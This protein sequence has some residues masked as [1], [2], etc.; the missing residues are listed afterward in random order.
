MKSLSGKAKLALAALLVAVFIFVSRQIDLQGQ[1]AAA[2]ER[3]QELGWIGFAVF[4][5]LYVAST[6][7]FLAPTVLTLGAGATYGVVNGTILV[8]I[9]SML[10][11]ST[12]F[13]LGRYFARDVVASKVEGNDGFKA[14]EKAVAREGWKIV[15]LTRLSPVFPFSLLNY[16]YGLTPVTFRDYFFA[17]WIGMLPGTLMYVYLGK[18]G[19]SIATI[20]AEGHERSPGEWALLVVGLAVTVIVTLFVTRVARNALANA[21]PAEEA[22]ETVTPT[23]D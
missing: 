1:F 16:T 15:G 5:V 9:S 6:V 2:L 19:E 10:G 3:I 11:A 22:P 17:S 7:F 18:A 21:V 4:A 13:F 20:G 8:S 14:I 12:A 23:V